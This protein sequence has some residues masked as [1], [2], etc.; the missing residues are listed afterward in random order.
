MES[1]GSIPPEEEPRLDVEFCGVCGRR[2][3]KTVQEQR[4]RGTPK[5]RIPSK[6]T[7]QNIE[8]LKA[9]IL[10][11]QARID[12]HTQEL[13]KHTVRKIALERRLEL[14]EEVVQLS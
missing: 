10:K 14:L 9:M 2:R 3:S 11:A 8:H 13:E 7:Q 12:K 4:A 5:P 1:T 6:V